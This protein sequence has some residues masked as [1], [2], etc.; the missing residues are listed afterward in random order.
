MLVENLIQKL[1][2]FRNSGT[3]QKSLRDYPLQFENE[4]I[5]VRCV[6]TSNKAGGEKIINGK[7][8]NIIVDIKNPFVNLSKWRELRNKSASLIDI[9]PVNK[10]RNKGA[11]GIRFYEMS[12]NPTDEFIKLLLEFVFS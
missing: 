9:T 6:E 1:Q 12:K 8:W 11:F 5:F 3:E 2:S 4:Y 10:G 7:Q